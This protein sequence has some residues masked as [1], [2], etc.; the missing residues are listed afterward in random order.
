MVLWT[1]HPL[2]E[3][4]LTMMLMLLGPELQKIVSSLYY[5]RQC[6]L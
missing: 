1:G 2:T 6:W 5:N 4:S 3:D